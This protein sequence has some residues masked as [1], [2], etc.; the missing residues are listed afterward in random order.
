[1]AQK[2]CGMLIQFPCALGNQFAS[3]GLQS[4]IHPLEGEYGVDSNILT[5]IQE[6][7]SNHPSRDDSDHSPASDFEF[8][9]SED[10]LIEEE[11][12]QFGE[13]SSRSSHEHVYP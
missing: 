13:A 7:E 9:V 3:M 10:S 11:N 12:A 4:T 1:M 2:D 8:S 5:E 6:K